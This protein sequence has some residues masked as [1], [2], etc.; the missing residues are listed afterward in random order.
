MYQKITNKIKD[1]R[2]AEG[3]L[4]VCSLQLLMALVAELNQGYLTAT[5]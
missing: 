4:K 5:K 2:R 1:K 3:A